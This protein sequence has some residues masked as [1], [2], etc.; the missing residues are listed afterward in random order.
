MFHQCW[1][2]FWNIPHSCYYCSFTLKV[3]YPLIMYFTCAY[4][5]IQLIICIWFMRSLRICLFG[6]Y[7]HL[8]I[9]YMLR[10]MSVE[11]SNLVYLKTKLVFPISQCNHL[12]L[13]WIWMKLIFSLLQFFLVAADNSILKDF[14][15]HLHY[16][17][18]CLW[19]L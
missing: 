19:Q 9:I 15:V 7:S 6:S 10:A 8:P 5:T 18:L 12:W 3:L 11:L 17:N 2:T 16:Y 4:W 13:N 1:W 14:Y